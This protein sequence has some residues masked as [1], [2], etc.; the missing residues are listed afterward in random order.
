VNRDRRVRAYSQRQEYSTACN[1]GYSTKWH[2]S[3]SERLRLPEKAPARLVRTQYSGWVAASIAG[4]RWGYANQRGNERSEPSA[5]G[6]SCLD[7]AHRNSTD[8][9]YIRKL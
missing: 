5:Q 1:E 7:K 6:L 9:P 2:V 3:L 8:P 4:C